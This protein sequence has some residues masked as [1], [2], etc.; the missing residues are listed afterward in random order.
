M[1]V[2]FLFLPFFLLLFWLGDVVKGELGD[3]LE[4]IGGADVEAHGQAKDV[5]E[6]GALF[7][8]LDHTYE[9]PMRS[10]HLRELLLGELSGEA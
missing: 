4:K 5:D 6:S 10:T 3:V 2:A 1:R 8:P 7:S 9:V